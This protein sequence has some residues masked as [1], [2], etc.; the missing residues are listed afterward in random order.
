MHDPGRDAGTDPVVDPH[1]PDDPIA[2]PPH[3][4]AA[5]GIPRDPAPVPEPAVTRSDPLAVGVAVLVMA[6]L[7]GC[8]AIVLIAAGNA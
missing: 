1:A 3:E 7:L 2:P 6:A 4:V 5:P 8:A